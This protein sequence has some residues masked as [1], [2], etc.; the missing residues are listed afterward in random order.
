MLTIVEFTQRIAKYYTPYLGYTMMYLGVAW[1]LA[2]FIKSVNV[3]H[4]S[5]QA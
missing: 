1:A 5:T 4:T 2:K 3:Q